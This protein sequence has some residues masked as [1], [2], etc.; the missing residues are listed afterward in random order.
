MSIY[1]DVNYYNFIKEFTNS[2]MSTL[3]DEMNT[4]SAK[5]ITLNNYLKKEENIYYKVL[6]VI[7][8]DDDDNDS[9]DE[10]DNNENNITKTENFEQI[11]NKCREEIEYITKQEKK[12]KAKVYTKKNII[13]LYFNYLFGNKSSIKKFK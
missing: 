5:Q 9:V 4:D 6:S 3:E 10:N 8:G 2:A 12:S 11:Y 1:T 7:K 13:K